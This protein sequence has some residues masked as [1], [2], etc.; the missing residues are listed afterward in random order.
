MTLNNKILDIWHQKGI[1]CL[2]D[3]FDK[4]LLMSFEHLKRKYDL[5]NQTFFC[6]PQLGSFLRANLGPE[7]I[8]PVVNDVERLLC[9][10]RNA[11]S[12]PNVYCKMRAQN[13]VCINLEWNGS[14]ISLSQLMN[15]SVQIYVKAA[16]RLLFTVVI[17]WLTIILHI[18]YTLPKKN[19]TLSNLTCQKCASG[20]ILKLVPFY[21]VPVCAQKWGLS[22]MTSAL[23]D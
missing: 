12:F 13:L 10:G 20:L 8:L 5:S 21:I 18:N 2:E 3:C 15:S 9:E 7:L 11:N 1:H 6:Y 19:Y 17:D 23:F 16:C 4:W 22:G 14:Q